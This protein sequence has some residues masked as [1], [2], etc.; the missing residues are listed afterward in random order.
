MFHEYLPYTFMLA[1]NIG[2][3]VLAFVLDTPD[4]IYDGF[5]KIIQSRSILVTDYI[6]IGGI[7]AA[8][9][10]VSIVGISA[11]VMLFRQKI[12][13]TG[14]T[15]MALFLSIGFAF[16]GKNVFNMIPLTF[17]VWLFAK[18]NKEPFSKYV[19]SALLVATISPTISE[20][21]FLGMTKPIIEIASGVL[22]GF[23]VGFI[24]PAIAAD[25]VKVHSGFNLY[26]MGFAGGL[27]ATV[28]A[29]IYR[30]LGI[31]IIP[32]DH[33]SSG[34][35]TIFAI[36]LYSFAAIML[37]IGLL[38]SLATENPKESIKKTMSNFLKIHSHDGRLVTD[39]Y[40][41][42]GKSIYIN[43]AVLC[44]FPT[45]LVLALGADLNGPALA[46]ILTII[47]FGS[48]G[49]HIKNVA[50]VIIGAVISAY[51]NIIDPAAPVNIVAI[52]FSS[53]LAPI[54]GRF[55]P[56]W[57]VIAGILHV[58]IA[59][60]IGDLNG[61]LNLYN[62]GFAACF[63]ALFLLPVITIFRKD[64]YYRKEKYR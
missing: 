41:M 52:L 62:N 56:F 29:T 25:S 27:V 53:A 51:I 39:Y 49:K 7:G 55:G 15:I 61:G 19:L 57:G 34:N 64:D 35:N 32:A 38:S 10:N 16:F 20:I 6:D 60:F 8:L 22:L 47:G 12:L 40:G 5:M 46:G 24:F 1:I 33:W 13:P 30:N 18:Y 59:L 2:F 63:V 26:N 45:T 17:G 37:A 54:A 42:Y 44:I 23:F 50:P 14:A 48:L 4:A 36:L 21:A 31:E 9:L 3:L 58:N 28:I 43:M 11:V